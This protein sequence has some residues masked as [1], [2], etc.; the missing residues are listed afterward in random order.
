MWTKTFGGPPPICYTLTGE[1]GQ[2]ILIPSSRIDHVFGRTPRTVTGHSLTLT[3]E[4]ARF[5]RERWA[6]PSTGHD[7]GGD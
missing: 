3:E 7:R 5:P 1:G 2:T 6:P 4:S